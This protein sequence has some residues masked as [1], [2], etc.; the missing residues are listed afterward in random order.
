MGDFV[1]EQFK[2]QR[3]GTGGNEIDPGLCNINPLQKLLHLLVGSDFFDIQ[4]ERTG[5]PGNCI[6]R[7]PVGF[8]NCSCID[9]LANDPVIVVFFHAPYVRLV[10]GK[11]RK[12]FKSLKVFRTVIGFHIDPFIGLPD[13]FLHI[14]GPFQVGR[15]LFF[16][17]GSGNGW[18]F[19]KQLFILIFLFH[20][21]GQ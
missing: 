21:T 12:I 16:P 8:G 5:S 17:L 11:C 4:A 9:I 2:C 19:R 1:N 10:A 13:Q 20:D 3:I 15:N 6:H 14:I 7:N 18:K